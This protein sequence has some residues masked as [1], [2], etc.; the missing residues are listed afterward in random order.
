VLIAAVGCLV[1]CA[2]CTEGQAFRVPIFTNADDCL[3]YVLSDEICAT[4]VPQTVGNASPS[5]Q[6]RA[7]DTACWAER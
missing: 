5:A 2:P 4:T 6:H 3:S 7:C 1:T